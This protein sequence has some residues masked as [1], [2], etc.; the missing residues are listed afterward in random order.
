MFPNKKENYDKSFTDTFH[1]LG[2]EGRNLSSPLLAPDSFFS[3][4]PK[5]S[6]NPDRSL[7]RT[8]RQLNGFVKKYEIANES[9]LEDTFDN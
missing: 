6:I 2:I 5:R 7:N 8:A 4:V 3:N 9:K 1:E